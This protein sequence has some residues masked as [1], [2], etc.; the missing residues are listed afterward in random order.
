MIFDCFT[1]FNESELLEVRLNELNS[2]VDKF[3][4]CEATHTH[5]GNPKPLNF[6]INKYPEF[7]NKITYVVDDNP[8]H[9]EQID[10]TKHAKGVGGGPAWENENHQRDCLNKGLSNLGLGDLI[11]VSDLDEIPSAEGV[12]QAEKLIRQNNSVVIFQHK[13]YYYMLNYWALDYVGSKIMTGHKFK[14]QMRNSPQAVRDYWA[15]P[16]VVEL[17]SGWH[18]G[19]LGGVE[20]IKYKFSN[21]AHQE[22]T[23]TNE[24][25]N[26]L[27]KKDQMVD[28]WDRK[29]IKIPLDNSFPKFLVDNQEKFKQYIDLS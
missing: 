24:V 16:D 3:V 2:V 10:V 7:K 1:F 22:Y 13:T 11:I 12:K 27:A 26:I 6:D 14:N 29:L 15:G 20:R 4:I 28:M 18:F 8:P 19:W 5:A 17:P 23:K 9:K 25:P 21:F